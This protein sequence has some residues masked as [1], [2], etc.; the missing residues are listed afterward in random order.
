M[1]ATSNVESESRTAVI[2]K[3]DA[4]LP[5]HPIFYF[6]NL[7]D[8]SLAHHDRRRRRPRPVSLSSF[9]NLSPP[10]DKSLRI[11]AILQNPTNK[12]QRQVEA[13]NAQQREKAIARKEAS[14]TAGQDPLTSKRG[15]RVVRRMNNGR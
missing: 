5:L 4:T 10:P 14:K 11:P 1:A 12:S 8:A 7:E 3:V 2:A 9:L 15:K 6:L 13:F